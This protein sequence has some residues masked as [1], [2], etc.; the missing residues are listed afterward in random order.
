MSKISNY[1][2]GM[3]EEGTLIYDNNKRE[4]VPAGL[5]SRSDVHKYR[6]QR[7]KRRRNK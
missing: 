3:E 4:Y 5:T 6:K 7:M 1:L 2:I